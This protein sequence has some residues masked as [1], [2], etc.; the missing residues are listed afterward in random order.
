[1][2]GWLFGTGS[3]LL[4]TVAQLFMKWGMMHLPLSLLD[5]VW[6]SVIN[7][8]LAVLAVFCGLLGYGFSMVCWLFALRYLPLS[9]AYP[10]L[11]LSYVMVY[12]LA[13]WLPSFNEQTSLLRTAG[14]V[15]ILFGVALTC[16]KADSKSGPA[17][18]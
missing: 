11:S 4:V 16:Y 18:P 7:Y 13:L 17:E 3:M 9:R 15:I 10:L 12:L 2:T 8:P 14:V 6:M 1:M 5:N